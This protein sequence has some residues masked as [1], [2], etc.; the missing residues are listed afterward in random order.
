MNIG[1][2]LFHDSERRIK[3]KKKF[4]LAVKVELHSEKHDKT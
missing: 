2:L 1:R 3:C 4:D